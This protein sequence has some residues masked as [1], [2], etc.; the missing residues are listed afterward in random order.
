MPGKHKSSLLLVASL[1]LFASFA[2]VL[3]SCSR[4]QGAALNS[5]TSSAMSQVAGAALSAHNA[6]DVAV[7][8]RA[9]NAHTPDLL[10]IP[11]VIGTGTG[12]GANGRLA[13]LVL[14]RRA[15]VG[16]I[17]GTVDGVQTEVRVVGDVTPYARGGGGLTCGTS[18]GN[19]LECA[20]GTIGAVVLKGSTKY[21]LSCNHVYAR[22]NAASIGEREDAPGRYDGKPRCSQTPQCGTL[23]QFVNISFSGNNTIDCAIAQM[24]TSNPTSVVQSG[25]YTASSTVASPSVG[26]AVK[27][28]GRTSG[29]T[30]G[31]IQA[32]NVTIQVGYTAGVATFTGQIMTPG[33]FIRSGDSG[34][35]MVTQSGNNPV[36][37]C[38]AG[39]S[40]GAFANPIGP[41]L[42][43][44]GATVA[45]Q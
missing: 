30:T 19:D 22:E 34:S 16:N 15:G 36:G 37:L 25:G 24:S 41:V 12:V 5:P 42:Q 45:T 20:A 27:K 7:A 33:S 23:A 10:K 31:T 40:G 8:M 21:L 4:D 14:T 18:T 28:S 17:P 1:L 11:D 29:L 26:L 44:F 6:A 43:A 2:L 35:L 39:G 13:V 38:F 32:I 3:V 9:Q